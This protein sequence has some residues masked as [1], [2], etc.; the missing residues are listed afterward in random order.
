MAVLLGATKGINISKNAVKINAIHK[1]IIKAIKDLDSIRFENLG[2][3]LIIGQIK[4][5][6]KAIEEGLSDANKSL[7]KYR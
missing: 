7:K 2:D 1:S 4:Y 5:D 6:L 3:S